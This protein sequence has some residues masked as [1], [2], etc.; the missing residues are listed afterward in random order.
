VQRRKAPGVPFFFPDWFL[1]REIAANVR[2]FLHCYARGRLLDIGC[3]EKPFA[4]FA[5]ANVG[6]WLGFDLPGNPVADAHGSADALPFPDASFETVLCTEV[7]EHV[8]G[9]RAAVSEIA[10]VLA[11]GGHAVVTMPLLYPLHEEP[12][13]YR[14]YTPY[15]LRAIFD[16]AGLEIVEERRMATGLRAAAVIANV[17]CF[18][19]GERLPGGRSRIGRGALLPVYALVNVSTMLLSCVVDD[20][21]AAA[22]TAIVARR[23][24]RALAKDGA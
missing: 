10:R 22:G 6:S 1:V 11:D 23:R 14:R 9:A 15:G 19:W 12:H 4:V 24:P 5:N 2:E 20:P 3:G 18:N 17:S 21:R 16:P 7:L 8:P 13:D